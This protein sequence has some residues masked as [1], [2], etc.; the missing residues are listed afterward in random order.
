MSSGQI[1]GMRREGSTE[2]VYI[3]PDVWLAISEAVRLRELADYQKQNNKRNHHLPH[4]ANYVV[5]NS[6]D[7][8]S[9][10]SVC[11]HFRQAL[12]QIALERL[13]V[14]PPETKGEQRQIRMLCNAARM[15]ELLME[16][17][18][19]WKRDL[20]RE[21]AFGLQ[22][23]DAQHEHR[24]PKLYLWHDVLRS[25]KNVRRVHLANIRI[26]LG[27]L[28]K[29]T[30]LQHL[31]VENGHFFNI[32]TTDRESSAGPAHLSLQSLQ[33]LETTPADYHGDDLP[34]ALDFLVSPAL[35]HLVVELRSF[36]AI[37]WAACTGLREL[38]LMM[39]ET[40]VTLGP[41][42]VVTALERCISLQGLYLYGI[43]EN[44]LNEHAV[45]FQK[46]KHLQTIA[47]D[48]EMVE[49][50]VLGR[51]VEHLRL[52]PPRTDSRWRPYEWQG[53]DWRMILELIRKSTTPIKTLDA[54]NFWRCDSQNSLEILE[55]L[56]QS[57][58]ALEE[59]GLVMPD[60]QGIIAAIPIIARLESLQTI[61]L[62]SP[63][64]LTHRDP[65]DWFSW[66]EAR[67]RDLVALSKS[68]RLR[69][70]DL[71][72]GHVWRWVEL[73]TWIYCGPKVDAPKFTY[74]Q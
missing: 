41:D 44:V 51:P 60:A 26:D 32:P 34:A 25:L 53:D 46:L 27:A 13:R 54:I 49:H 1:Q 56:V 48:V 58:G 29:L 24:A 47:C 73:K 59:L 63:E 68:K 16:P 57:F 7:L 12:F 45:R 23:Y 61:A 38:V 30:N 42:K 18:G 2:T 19:A 39:G 55:Q 8:L 10:S 67:L 9:L 4:W 50:L 70:L 65:Q 17:E 43:S 52:G 66:R 40:Y 71:G 14:V 6:G 36:F 69:E 31:A 33:V 35:T 11:R 15:L 21:F 74:L 72:D 62:I 22:L 3:P 64:M 20:V 28:L 5:L 37:R